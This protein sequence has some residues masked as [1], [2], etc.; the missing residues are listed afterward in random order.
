[1]KTVDAVEI[2]KMYHRFA[3]TLR[4]YNVSGRENAFD[5]LVNLMLAK[6]VDELQNDK[7]LL[8]N[9][10]G[11]AYDD[12]FRLQ[13]RLQRL[14]KEGMQKFLG[15]DV[16][17]IDDKQIDQAFR[18]FKNDPDATRDT[19]RKF[20]RQLKFFTN[21]DFAF[22]DVHNEKLFDQNVIVL[23]E[24]VRMLQDIR[25]RTDSEN[26]FLGDLFENFLDQGVK[27][28]EG[29]FFTPIPFVRFMVNSLPVAETIEQMSDPPIVLDYACGAGHFLNEYARQASACI[30]KRLAEEGRK[31]SG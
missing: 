11:A 26:Q 24:V 22:I 28:S 7:K 1:M 17:Y 30:K 10:K 27:Q 23:R 25:L 12:D 20:V 21:N 2:G 13:D 9:W 5:K 31:D 19:V 18:R 3:E 16:T 14:Y 29:Q 4:K 8:F 15:E 6:V